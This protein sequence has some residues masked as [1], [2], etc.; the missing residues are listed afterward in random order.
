MANTDRPNGFKPV[1]TLSGSPWQGSVER[2]E[3]DAS[4]AIIGV[5]DLVQMTS[6]GYPDLYAAGEIS[7][8]GVVVGVG[9]WESNAVAGKVGDSFLSTGDAT[10]SGYGSKAVAL[11]TAGVIYV[12]TAP[13]VILEAQE[14]AVGAAIALADVGANIEIIYAA[15]NTTTGISNM[16]LD[17]STVAQTATLPLKIHSLVQRPDN[18]LGASGSPGARW[19]VVPT[20][21]HHYRAALGLQE[22]T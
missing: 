3:L 10:L 1:G 15:P 8:L 14:D 5:G 9:S 11:N 20:I 12:C 22:N 4:H 18:E 16:E 19:L 6:D 17:S 2:F 13:D 7:L 21:T